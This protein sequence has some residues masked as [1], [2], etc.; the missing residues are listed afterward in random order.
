[1]TACTFTPAHEPWS[2]AVHKG[3][4]RTSLDEER[5]SIAKTTHEPGDPHEYEAKCRVCGQ[6]GMVQITL[7]PEKA[8]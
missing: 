6:H 3:G 7:V 2:C 5:C 8:E 1:M 4:L